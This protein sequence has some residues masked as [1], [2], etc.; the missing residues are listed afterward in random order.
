MKERSYLSVETDV[1]DKIVFDQE[2]PSRNAKS[3]RKTPKTRKVIL[4]Q[5]RL[6]VEL[7]PA[8]IENDDEIGILIINWDINVSEVLLLLLFYMG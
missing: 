3:P 2:N 6:G 5:S 8:S 4:P 7:G 1:N